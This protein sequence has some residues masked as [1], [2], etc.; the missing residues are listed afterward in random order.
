MIRITATQ[1]DLYKAA[2][3]LAQQWGFHFV[4][5]ADQA[6]TENFQLQLTPQRLQLLQTDKKSPGP[7]A[8]DFAT[9][10]VAHRRLFGGGKGQTI[11]KAV[12]LN[13]DSN[14]LIL[15]ATAGMGKD[16]F[17]FASL[18][19]QVIMME[20]SPISAA[21]L[22]N[23]LQRAT[24]DTSIAEIIARMTLIY[25]DARELIH[26]QNNSHNSNNSDNKDFIHFKPGS[27]FFTDQLIAQPDV[28][29]LDPMFPHRKKSALVKKE[30]LAFQQL[31]G[32]DDDSGELLT[33]CLPL[34]KKRVVV[35]RPI[36]APYLNQQKPSLSMNMKKH[37]FDIYFTHLN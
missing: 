33:A 12:G 31:I 7:I 16:A 23:A 9:G 15:D 13:K 4:S 27:S 19:A 25:G 1:T 3:D 34:A 17:V 8:I 2:K 24:S 14:P 32:N 36:K 35:K 18:G 22:S 10:Q 6:D 5:M 21:L 26:V 37:R 28:I 20:R 29:Y 30:M 11:A